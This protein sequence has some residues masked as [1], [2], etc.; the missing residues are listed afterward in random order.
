[1]Q[2]YLIQFSDVIADNA[3]VKVDLNLAGFDIDLG[4]PSNIPVEDVLLVIIDRLHDFISR[5]IGPPKPGDAWRR[6]RIEGRL[7]HAVE[8]PSP[9]T[10]PIHGGEHLHI[11]NRMQPKA[12]RNPLSHDT[13]QLGLD[14]FRTVRRNDIEVTLAFFAHDRE[15]ALIHAVRID[16][17]LR[18][19]CLAKNF[20]EC[21]RRQA[22]RTDNV[23]EYGTWPN[24]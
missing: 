23:R 2:G 15:L 18:G 1:G 16:N 12:L 11:A 9:E 10:A 4:H 14:R 8:R 24:G 17:D 7:E 20:C 6:L 3:P 19:R 22:T 5:G 13:Q 21:D